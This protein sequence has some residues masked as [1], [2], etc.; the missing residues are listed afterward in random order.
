MLEGRRAVR[1]LY[2]DTECP[3]ENLHLM[4]CDLCSLDSIRQFAKI[5]NSEEARLDVLICNANLTWSTDIVTIDGFNT[6]VQ[7]NYLGHFL[8][9]N[10]LLEKLKQC[11]PSRVINVSSSAHRSETNLGK[12]SPLT[13]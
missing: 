5:Y 10:L 11:R 3:K 4:E 13:E 12:L 1:Q 9:T 8:L 6:I 7:A 2:T